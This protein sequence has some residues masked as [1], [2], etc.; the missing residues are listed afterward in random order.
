MNAV[1]WL[2][3]TVPCCLM[4]TALDKFWHIYT[5]HGA[6]L[7]Q[8]TGEFCQLSRHRER[9]NVGILCVLWLLWMRKEAKECVCLPFSVYAYVLVCVHL[10]AYLESCP[11]WMH[12]CMCA[13]EVSSVNVFMHGCIECMCRRVY[14]CVCVWGLLLAIQADR[15]QVVSVHRS[16]DQVET[17]RRKGE[18]PGHTGATKLLGLVYHYLNTHIHWWGHTRKHTHTHAVIAEQEKKKKKQRR[19]GKESSYM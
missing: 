5:H 4:K 12:L 1:G 6:T 9:G 14:M 2:W 17:W 3:I 7:L 13:N 15:C 11:A 16:S 8:N 10:S 19:E 18:S